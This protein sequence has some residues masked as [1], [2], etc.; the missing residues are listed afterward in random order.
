[1]VVWIYQSQGRTD[2]LLRW[3]L[4]AG[5][6]TIAGIVAGAVFGSIESVALGYA[7]VTVIVLGYPRFAIPGRLIGMRPLD[8]LRAVGGPLGAAILMAGAMLGLG[9]VF[10]RHVSNGVDFVL[11]A[12]VG[13]VLYLVICGVLRV[14]GLEEFRRT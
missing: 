10:S 2:W 6:V 1:T 3:G 14:R 9:I 8:V 4:V 5:V 7:I 12:L 11:R 13:F